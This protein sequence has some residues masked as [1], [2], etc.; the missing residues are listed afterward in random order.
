MAQLRATPNLYD[1]DDVYD[2]Y[3]DDDSFCSCRLHHP[4]CLPYSSVYDGDDDDACDGSCYGGNRG[5]GDDGGCC[6]CRRRPS[7]MMMP[8]SFRDD[9]Y[10]YLTTVFP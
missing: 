10:D 2:V 6:V 7:Q 8:Q 4:R 3:D 5:D 9:F 1:D